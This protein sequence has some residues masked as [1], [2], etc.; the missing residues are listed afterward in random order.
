[1]NDIYIPTVEAAKILHVAPQLLRQQARNGTLPFKVVIS[2]N[3]IHII[4]KSFFEYI[5]A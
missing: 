4:R 2:G 3:R 1:M 5:G